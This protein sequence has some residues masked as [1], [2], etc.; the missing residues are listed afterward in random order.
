MTR[1]D[2]PT[3]PMRPAVAHPNP[4]QHELRKWAEQAVTAANQAGQAVVLS[5]PAPVVPEEALLLVEPDAL[6]AL[7][8]SASASTFSALG[9]AHELRAA[10]AGRFEEIRG[11]A[12]ALWRDWTTV[13]Y[14][15]AA[16]P[17]ARLIGGFAFREGGAHDTP[18]H[19]FGDA[20]FVLPRLRYEVTGDTAWLSRAVGRD[21]LGRSVMRAAAVE[22]LLAVRAALPAVARGLRQTRPL[23]T[24]VGSQARSDEDWSALVTEI[25]V[26]IADGLFEKVVAARRTVLEFNPPPEPIAV[27]RRLRGGPPG[28]IRFA[29]RRPGTTFLGATPERLVTQTGAEVR[30]EALAGSARSSE[31]GAAARLLSSPK[32]LAEHDFVLQFLLE[33]LSRVCEVTPPRPRPEVHALRHLLHLRTPIR[34]RR[35]QPGHVLDLVACL[36]PTPAVGGVPTDAAVRWI[37]GHEPVARGWYAGPV[38]WF[39]PSGD[40]EFAVALRSGVLQERFAY[41]YAGAGIVRDSE[42][43]SELDETDLKLATLH[44]PECVV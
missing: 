27:L 25:A 32:E 28:S 8:S 10:G 4:E 17:R 13:S 34:A 26:G 44:D 11:Q 43:P 33:R 12:A 6:G 19:G 15:D 1:L 37:E 2:A 22:N 14:G 23:P 42:P 21:E 30:T 16:P 20:W 5:I 9:A 35:L 41:L 40:G 31:P 39:E 7:W 18:W 29:L 38:G 36:H 3:V 24:L